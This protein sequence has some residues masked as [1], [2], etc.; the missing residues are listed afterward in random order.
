MLRA[1][2]SGI[3]SGAPLLFLACAG[4]AAATQTPSTG[5]TPGAPAT[6][7][8]APGATAA[9]ITVPDLRT[10][11]SILAHDSMRG[12]ETGTPGARAAADYLV[13]EVRRLGLRPAGENGTYL[14]RVPLTRQA[15]RTEAAFRGTQG[16]E[17]A[18]TRDDLVL[19]SGFTDLPGRPRPTGQG[20]LVYG[21]Y[22][23]DPAVTQQQELKPEQLSGAALVVRFGAPEGV[24]PRS[25]QPRIPLG[26]LMGPGSPLS[27]I[28]LVSEG[29]LQPLWSHVRSS[30]HVLKL[31]GGG[32]EEPGGGPPIFLVSPAAAQRMLGTPLA[33]ARQPRT[34]LGTFR[35]TVRQT[36]DTVPAW[37]VVAVLPGSDPRR[38]TQY[39]ALGAHYDHVGVGEPVNGDSIYN[40]A[41]DDASG[42]S[43]VLEI[44][45][46]FASLPAAQR[47]GRSL[48]FVWHTAEEVGLL[49][50][51]W[52]TEHSTVRRDS[53]VAQINI[54]MIGRN[55]PDSIFLV[56]SRRLSTQ[57][58]DTVEAVNRRQARPL[59][60]D[61]SFDR[62][63][64]PEQIY[65][66]SDHYNYGRFGIP[67]VFFT[68]G[69]HED[70]HKPSDEPETLNYEKLAKVSQFI[71]DVVGA[72]AS[73]ATRPVVNQ[74]VP[75][76]GSPC[77]Q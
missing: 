46:R 40:G 57:L 25:A 56:G 63:G 19:I 4:C 17:R 54:D 8:P 11:V 27:A 53:I 73:G 29:P 49:G 38:A 51:E 43:G 76:P 52:Y 69:L 55:H 58:G 32:G 71:G 33:S 64:H 37:N 36:T 66:R 30:G 61:Y 59:A 13:S 18:L 67:V 31:A 42:T 15:S 23:V 39:V 47:P 60:L 44:A 72:V 62:P 48:L 7:L 68:T 28:L 14:A 16:A 75:P 9:A 34:G 3:R 1:S 35:Y 77:V 45:E 41:D 24:N 12:R 74:P 20:N 21:G 2:L 5:S 70:Y 26:P 22:M 50:S 65:C 6:T 10:R